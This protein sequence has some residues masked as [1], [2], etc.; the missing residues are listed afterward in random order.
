MNGPIRTQIRA[1]L[2]PQ[3]LR[4][5][6]VKGEYVHHKVIHAAQGIK[7][8]AQDLESAIAGSPLMVITDDMEDDEIEKMEEEV[9]VSRLLSHIKLSDRGVAVQAS[10]LGAMEALLSFLQNECS[11]PIPVA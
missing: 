9:S 10:T 11:P 5:M 1:L 3:P 4:E 6:R 8:S 2:T 7:I